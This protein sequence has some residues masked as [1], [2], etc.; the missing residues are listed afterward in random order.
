MAVPVKIKSSGGNEGPLL[1][2]SDSDLEK[3][4][5]LQVEDTLVQP[6]IEGLAHVIISNMTGCSNYVSAGTVIGEAAGVEIIEDNT[7]RSHN[8]ASKGAQTSEEQADESLVIRNI[9]SV[10][11][12]KEELRKL[13]GKP[14]FLDKKQRQDLLNF[15]TDHHT[16]FCLDIQERGET[17]LVEMETR[18]GDEAP[19]K[20]A[21]HRMP[22]A[23][24]QEVAKQLC[25]MQEGGVIEPSD[26]PWSSPVV[27][28]RK[29]DGNLRFCV[30]YRELNRVTWKDTF[31]L[32]RVDNLLD[33]VGQSKYFTTFHHIGP[34]QWVL[35]DT[36]GT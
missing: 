9:K 33:Q 4:T 6:T 27:M 13:I 5:G 21:T 8:S 7:P 22:F 11:D 10:D 18:T 14:K 16:A 20:V 26:G 31:P 32:P 35:A 15:I 29:K 25:N 34:R 30:D 19:R 24:R 2:K 1:V 28:V 12:R 17:N 23:V 3:A 36:S